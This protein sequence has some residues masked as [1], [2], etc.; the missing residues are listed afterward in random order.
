MATR[1]GMITIGQSPRVDVVPEVAAL[2]GRPMEVVEA[3]ALDGLSLEEV[4]PV[5]A[6]TGG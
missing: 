3:G 4:R 6:R 2:V 1:V 5:G